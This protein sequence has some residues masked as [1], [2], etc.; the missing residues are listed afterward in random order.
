[1]VRR[2]PDLSSRKMERSVGSVGLSVVPSEVR[3]MDLRATLGFFT[4]M[5]RSAS[6]YF[7]RRKLRAWR[8]KRRIAFLNPLNYSCA[9]CR[10]VV[11]MGKGSGR[12]LLYLIAPPS[13]DRSAILQLLALEHDVAA[14]ADIW[15]A[16]EAA[17]TVLDAPP[18]QSALRQVAL[19]TLTSPL[20]TP[21]ELQAQTYQL[22]EWVYNSVHLDIL[23]AIAYEDLDLEEINN[24]SE[25]TPTY[26]TTSIV[27]TTHQQLICLLIA[28][29][30]QYIFT[31]LFTAHVA[32]KHP[33]PTNAPPCKTQLYPVKQRRHYDTRK[34]RTKTK[35]KRLIQRA[36]CLTTNTPYK[37]KHSDTH[38]CK[39]EAYRKPRRN[40]ARS[41]A[42]R[43]LGL[44]ITEANLRQPNVNS[45]KNRPNGKLAMPNP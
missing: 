1:V 39:T 41:G 5:R 19:D 43:R 14:A 26:S 32:H 35:S 20:I 11:P 24:W 34:S 21:Y 15:G 38:R 31:Y 44:L 27:N 8:M 12:A 29:A 2:R 36:T 10:V 28:F 33:R 25:L 7:R 16:W 3:R 17:L 37:H 4:N 9:A 22:T 18:I 6:L 42:L 23:T 13:D 45:N 30:T 40:R